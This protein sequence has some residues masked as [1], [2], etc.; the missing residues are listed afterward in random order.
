MIA[1]QDVV[2]SKFKFHA[3][4]ICTNIVAQGCFSGSAL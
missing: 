3:N 2:V 4:L 1:S